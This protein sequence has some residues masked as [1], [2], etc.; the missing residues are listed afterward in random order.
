MVTVVSIIEKVFSLSHRWTEKATI[1][2]SWLIHH[3]SLKILC[4]PWLSG[5]I[6]S[7]DRLI[8]IRCKI[9][10]NLYDLT[11]IHANNICQHIAIHEEDGVRD[12]GDLEVL[13]ELLTL[14]NVN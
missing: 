10:D 2:L 5:P 11:H 3:R 7:K 4:Y 12:S 9:I 13:R 6:L 14:I 1:W 8:E